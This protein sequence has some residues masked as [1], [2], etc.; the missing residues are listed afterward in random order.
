MF[1]KVL[2]RGAV[3]IFLSLMEPDIK[4]YCHQAGCCSDKGLDLYSGDAGSNLGYHNTRIFLLFLSLYFG[5][6]HD[7]HPEFLPSHYRDNLLNSFTTSAVIKKYRF[8]NA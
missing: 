5:I 7:H 6:G 1:A 3:L 4:P 8:R 2:G